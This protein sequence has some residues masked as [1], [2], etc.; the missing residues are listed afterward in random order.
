MIECPE[1]GFSGAIEKFFFMY[2]GGAFTLPNGDEL[3]Q[4][5]LRRIK[6]EQLFR[7]RAQLHFEEGDLLDDEALARECT[8]EFMELARTHAY[9][10]HFRITC[11]SC[12]KSW[13]VL[14]NVSSE[15]EVCG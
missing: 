11:P 5:A 8:N 13:D 10:H 2:T 6:T 14:F 7:R 9:A 3:Y 1:C 15:E 4:D 12:F